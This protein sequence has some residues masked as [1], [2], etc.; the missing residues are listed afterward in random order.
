MD[1]LIYEGGKLLL[2]DQR[3][4]P[5][6]ELYL[7]IRDYRE[8]AEAIVNMTVRGAPIIGVTAGFAYYLAAREFF[9]FEGFE[10]KLK[11][12]KS[13]L[14]AT[15]PTAVNLFWAL[16][17]MEN[18]FLGA[19]K[20]PK[21]PELLEREALSILHEDAALC[22]R[23]GDFGAEV[24]PENAGIMTHCNAGAL[25]TG[26]YGTALGVIRSA[27]KKGFVKM[28]YAN[29]TRPLFQGSRLTA[30]ELD[31]DAIPVTVQPDSAAA[32]LM[33]EGLVDIVIV[34]AD[35]IARSGD[36][37]NKIGTYSLAVLARHH[38]IPFYAAAPFTSVDLNI[39]SGNGIVIEHRDPDEVRRI[40][41][42]YTA[43][44]EISVYNPAFDVTPAELLTGIITDRGIFRPPFD[45]SKV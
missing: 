26:G 30:W 16:D 39:Q 27:H 7:E 25:A 28:V 36:F 22:R 8:A 1:A 15:R 11:I 33:R 34:G 5:G 10:D 31:R 45:L 13:E 38:G 44:P 14:A 40:G 9:G 29:E 35:R 32:S 21:L 19:K 37:A 23:I 6:E 12:A 18:V 3:Q 24:V 4:L 20:D 42:A 2:L 41:G 43:P 17:R